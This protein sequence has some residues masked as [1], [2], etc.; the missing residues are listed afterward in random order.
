MNDKMFAEKTKKPLK[1]FQT[2]YTKSEV[3]QLLKKAQHDYFIVD[4]RINETLSQDNIGIP[5]EKH[6]NIRDK[7]NQLAKLRNDIIQEVLKTIQ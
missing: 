7:L 2:G 6:K 1:V 5:V 4:L 3:I